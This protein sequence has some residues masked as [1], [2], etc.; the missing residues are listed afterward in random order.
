AGWAV[1]PLVARS[2]VD[3]ERKGADGASSNTNKDVQILLEATTDGA[4]EHLL[5]RAGPMAPILSAVLYAQNGTKRIDA[6]KSAHADQQLTELVLKEPQDSADKQIMITVILDNCE[7][8]RDAE[9]N[10]DGKLTF[11]GALD[12]SDAITEMKAL[13]FGDSAQGGIDDEDGKARNELLEESQF[14]R[15]NREM[16][17]SLKGHRSP[18]QIE[19]E[20]RT[21]DILA[22]RA[23]MSPTQLSEL[24][25]Q[26]KSTEVLKR[27][28][29]KDIAEHEAR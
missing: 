13:W 18:Y 12:R 11:Q 8:Y 22:R 16:L 29:A 6:V 7:R 23:Q 26:S 5:L 21:A 15:A 17:R 24:V 4:L 19:M 3:N 9:R 27:G 1:R 10:G 28:L 2:S 20:I 25:A 14:A